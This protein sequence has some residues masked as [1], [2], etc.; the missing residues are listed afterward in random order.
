MCPKR[1]DGD[2]DGSSDRRHLK[3]DCGFAKLLDASRAHG[4]AIAYK[5]SRLAVPL[6]INPIDR[7]FQHGGGAVVVFRGDEDK[8]IRGRD[9]RG[10]FLHH[11]VFVRRSTR[12]S[13][14]HRLVEE[15]HGEIAKIK[16]PSF[17]ALPLAKMLNNPLSRLF[18]KPSLA[19]T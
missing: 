17:N 6:R 19:C 10:P 12:H 15:W 14:R 1:G 9:L 16:K 5:G 7:V 4:A 3:L 18:G 8:S 11:V 13:R 2:V